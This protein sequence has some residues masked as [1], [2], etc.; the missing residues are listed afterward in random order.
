ME[1][2]E[3]FIKT[4]DQLLKYAALAFFTPIL[5][6]SLLVTYI[7]SNQLPER[8]TK[9]QTMALIRPVGQVSMEGDA[10]PEDSQPRVIKA[11]AKMP[12][13]GEQVYG[14]VCSGCHAVGAAGAP[15]FKNTQTWAPRIARGYDA[16]YTSVLKGKGVMPARGGASPADV[17]DY[18]LARATVYITSAAGGKF[19]EPKD[20]K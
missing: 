9:E 5:V 8:P 3:P 16:L 1:H 15:V 12:K 19:P 7:T 10:V 11:A 2:G 6:I 20:V 18:E 4:G 13:T 17:S 14:Q